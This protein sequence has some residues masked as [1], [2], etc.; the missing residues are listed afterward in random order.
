MENEKVPD[1]RLDDLIAD[2]TLRFRIRQ[3]IPERQEGLITRI[4]T[5]PLT[6]TIIGFLL[7]WG[8]GTLLT[9]KLKTKQLENAKALDESKAAREK[10]KTAIYG[11]AELMFNRYTTATLLA[12]SLD[13]QVTIETME[14]FKKRKQLHDD[15]YVKWNAELK[16]SQL[17]IRD[18]TSD[19]VY[20]KLVTFLDKRM[21]PHFAHVDS[22]LTD[23]YD[24]VLKHEKYWKY[25]G[26]N[27]Q[28]A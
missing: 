26:A 14:E 19:T 2:E 12:S 9:D 3:I 22:V 27:Q 15:A 24:A 11:I 25:E 16:V 20:R 7:T 1:K 6:A 10:A 18:I 8:I 13:R 23:G 5:N 28:F 4:S 21:M 17:T